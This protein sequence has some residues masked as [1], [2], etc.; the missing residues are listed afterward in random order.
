MGIFVPRLDS[1]QRPLRASQK[2]MRSFRVYLLRN[3]RRF[4]H[5]E[6]SLW[7]SRSARLRLIAQR[8]ALRDHAVPAKAG[9]EVAASQIADKHNDSFFIQ[10]KRYGKRLQIIAFKILCKFSNSH[11]TLSYTNPDRGFSRFLKGTK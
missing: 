7:R 9:H 4:L 1:E 5:D 6:L 3:I 2:L 11:Q 10:V 8:L